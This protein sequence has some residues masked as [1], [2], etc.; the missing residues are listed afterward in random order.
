MK[1]VKLKSDKLSQ[2]V[3]DVA[4]KA[5]VRACGKVE[6]LHNSIETATG[7][8][9]V[10]TQSYKDSKS[11]LIV[12][13]D[14]TTTWVKYAKEL[15]KQDTK[16]VLWGQCFAK[17]KENGI[18]EI[19]LMNKVGNAKLSALLKLP[20]VKATLKKAKADIVWAQGM[21]D[22]AVETKGLEDNLETLDEQDE[23]YIGEFI[24]TPADD[25]TDRA[26]WEDIAEDAAHIKR[27][28]IEV[29]QLA[30][31]AKEKVKKELHGLVL[32]FLNEIEIIEQ[33]LPPK[34]QKFRMDLQQLQLKWQKQQNRKVVQQLRQQ[35]KQASLAYKT[36]QN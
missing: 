2:I 5:F 32:A 12:I 20:E 17:K 16:N 31:E 24:D 26:N 10:L 13:G 3:S 29:Q 9:I 7:Y 14:L 15:K 8:L 27:R 33:P 34:F 22:E 28:L 35:L 19:Q 30:G 25:T 4:Q 18:T 1:I 11:S 21:S 23:V 6:I 36:L